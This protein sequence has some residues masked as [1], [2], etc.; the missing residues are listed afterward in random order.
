MF[1]TVVAYRWGWTNESPQTQ[2]CTTAD[3]DR[4][5]AVADEVADNSAGKYG[6]AVYAWPKD[7]ERTLHKYISSI[8]DEDEPYHNPRIDMFNG[9]GHKVH[10]AVTMGTV[11]EA[12]DSGAVQAPRSAVV[13]VW[14]REVIREQVQNCAFSEAYATRSRQRPA[15]D[16]PP[17]ATL[18]HPDTKPL[19]AAA[20]VQT[21]ELLAKAG[22][23]YQR[24]IAAHAKAHGPI[25]PPT[26]P[27]ELYQE[28]DYLPLTKLLELID[29]PA[30]AT[31]E[32]LLTEN[33]VLF[34]SAPGSRRN[35]QAWP[36]GYLDHVVD[37]M[38][39]ARHI[40]ALDSALG[41]P[42]AFSLSDALLVFYLHDL[43]K[44]WR[45]RARQDGTLSNATGFSSK[46]DFKAF[47]ERKLAEMGLIL[48]P[49][50]ANALKY[51]EG[52][53]DDYSSTERVMNELAAFCHKVD[54]WSARQCYEYPKAIADEWTGARRR[55]V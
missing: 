21:D 43:E 42:L 41:R 46:A 47:R 28:L 1:Y 5:C 54:I 16:Q 30:R 14:L 12:N 40:F 37:G 3:V 34:E 15:G 10:S 20:G 32:M 18:E 27:R 35:H 44:P 19:W 39:Y 52:E 23:A 22:Q 17:A 6:V 38:N 33:K 26:R 8:Y 13:P 49:I 24:T 29:Q 48:T 50:Q 55:A 36:G 31:C 51:V 4:A 9:I 11:W 2:F 45:I 53:G 25:A 7:N